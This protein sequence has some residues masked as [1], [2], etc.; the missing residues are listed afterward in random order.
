M[1]EVI[2]CPKGVLGAMEQPR[3]LEGQMCYVPSRD[4]FK[5]GIV[6]AGPYINEGS[7][8]AYDVFV[9]SVKETYAANSIRK[10]R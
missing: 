9:D 10:R 4:G 7:F 6:L 2:N 1:I 8:V 5:V 3:F